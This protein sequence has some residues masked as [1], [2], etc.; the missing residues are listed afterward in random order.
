[1][2]IS[3]AGRRG[4]DPRL[5]SQSFQQV[6]LPLSV[7]R[8]AVELKGQ[9]LIKKDLFKHSSYDRKGFDENIDKRTFIGHCTIYNCNASQFSLP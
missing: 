1:M 5:P 9:V 8:V 2:T 4:F 7:F 6:R 3:Q